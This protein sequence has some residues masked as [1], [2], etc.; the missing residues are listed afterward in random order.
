MLAEFKDPE[1]IQRSL[2]YAVSYKVRN[3]DAVF[4]FTTAMQI[5]ENRDQAWKFIQ[6]NWELVQAQFTTDIGADLVASTGNF[7]SANARDNVKNF[8]S[9]HKVSSSDMSFNTP[10]NTSTAALSFA[11]SGTQS[12]TVAIRPTQTVAH[13]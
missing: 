11:H 2:D 8:F 13:S 3:Q 5:D 7:C 4:Q 10:S 12:E 9:T 1:L 6:D